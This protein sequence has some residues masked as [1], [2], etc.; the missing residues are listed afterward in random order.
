MSC[1]NSTMQH[2]IAAAVRRAA[3]ETQQPGVRQSWRVQGVIT[4]AQP[5]CPTLEA[6]I[7]ERI[8]A[9]APAELVME[10]AHTVVA[11]TRAKLMA[12]RPEYAALVGTVEAA[13]LNEQAAQGKA[14]VP[15]MRTLTQRCMAT[16]RDSLR[17]LIHHRDAL[18]IAVVATEREI[19]QR[20]Q[21]HAV[22]RTGLGLAPRGRAS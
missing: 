10:I 14:D 6:V 1:R 22:A 3:P 12:A 11:H 8:A 7:D 17:S 21:Q 2:E 5:A 15:Q 19:A 16:L 9:G 18:D 13:Y 20:E 4:G